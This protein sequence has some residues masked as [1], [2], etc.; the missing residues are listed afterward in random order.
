MK[1][2]ADLVARCNKQI[3]DLQNPW[4]LDSDNTFLDWLLL[5]RWTRYAYCELNLRFNLRMCSHFNSI[6]LNSCWLT[7]RCT[8]QVIEGHTVGL[9]RY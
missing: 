7:S 9:L 4:H 6:C 8:L 5:G 2:F 3:A 1:D